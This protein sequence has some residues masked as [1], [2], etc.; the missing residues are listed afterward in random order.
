MEQNPN[1]NQ[2]EDRGGS[3]F[4]PPEKNQKQSAKVMPAAGASRPGRANSM[5]IPSGG[6]WD[7]A[8]TCIPWTKNGATGSHCSIVAIEAE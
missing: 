7:R 1:G 4:Q 3:R 2:I 5:G 8:T 6:D